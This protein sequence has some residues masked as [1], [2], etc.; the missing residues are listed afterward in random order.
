MARKRNYGSG[1]LAL[2]TIAGI[3]AI[4]F[5]TVMNPIWLYFNKLIVAMAPFFSMYYVLLILSAL[6]LLVTLALH[7]INRARAAKVLLGMVA[8]GWIALSLL[9]VFPALLVP[10]M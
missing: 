6:F 7:I 4:V 5:S 8:L 10:F 1:D 2:Y 3:L 9:Y